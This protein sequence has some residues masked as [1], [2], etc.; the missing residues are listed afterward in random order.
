MDTISFF[1][2][3]EKSYLCRVVAGFLCHLGGEWDR[4]TPR[5]DSLRELT[6]SVAQ[7]EFL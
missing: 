7:H 5:E 1:K 2:R 6:F 4:E 3:K